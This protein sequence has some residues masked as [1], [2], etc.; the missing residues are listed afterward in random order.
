MITVKVRAM[1]NVL[2][3]D[4]NEEVEIER[5]SAV[6]E[7]LRYGLLVELRKPVP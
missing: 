1:V 4:P 5:T 3:L 7:A 6:E 2:G